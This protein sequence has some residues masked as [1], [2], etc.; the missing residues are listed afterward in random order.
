MLVK[1]KNNTLLCAAAF[2]SAAW[3][4]LF[5]TRNV[6]ADKID[7]YVLAQMQKRHIPGLSLAIL[8]NGRADKMRGYG[9]ANVETNTPATEKTVYE[10]ASVTKPFTATAIMMLVEDGKLALDDKPGKYYLGFPKSWENVTV[11]SLLN[12]TSGLKNYLE[13][14]DFIKGIRDDVPQH[15]LMHSVAEFP[16]D[17]PVGEDWHY[18]NSGYFL[19]GSLIEKITNKSY[20]DFL[21][22]RI[23]RPLGMTATRL[24]DKRTI[25]PN[26]AAGY[27]WDGT[28]KNGEYVSPTQSF[29][30]GGLVSTAEDMAKFDAALYGEK[31]L[32]KATLELMWTPTVTKNGAVHTYGMGWG[33]MAKTAEGHRF[34]D[35]TGGIQG[36][37]THI[38]RYPEDKFTVVVLANLDSAQADKIARKIAALAAPALVPAPPPA[39]PDPDPALSQKF[40]NLILNAAKGDVDADFFAPDV[41]EFL[42][43]RIK[44]SKGVFADYGAMQTFTLIGRGQQDD[45]L[46]LVYRAV[47]AESTA[48]FTFL[49]NREQKVSLAS[50]M[51]EP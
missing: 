9:L 12:H 22:E 33:A 49:L 26:R 24:D 23:F 14:P 40:K 34:I 2:V 44:A 32:K 29:A 11:R 8:R 18:S 45:G 41:R 50:F 43:S 19:L 21:T 3:L 25:L 13:I 37:S 4:M 35:H 51:D 42:V 17:F 16:L 28:L 7:D 38:V 6:R 46:R 27:S 31:L 48:R 5:S 39:V 36:F 15:E 1:I 20:N 30:A 47:F 10:L